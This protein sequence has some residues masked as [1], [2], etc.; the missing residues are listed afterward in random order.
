[1]ITTADREKEFRH[2]LEE[3]LTKY[4]AQMDFIDEEGSDG[5]CIAV[6]RIVM[7]S[8]YINNKL[9]LDYCEFIV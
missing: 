6:C 1:M 4:C 8:V 5:R 7:P 9:A 3:L 2:A